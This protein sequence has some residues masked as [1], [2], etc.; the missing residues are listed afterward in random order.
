MRWCVERRLPSATLLSALLAAGVI[1]ESALS[2]TVTSAGTPPTGPA[3]FWAGPFAGAQVLGSLST[4]STTESIAATGALFHHFDAFASGAGGGLNFGYNWLPWG[5]KWL[6]GVVADINFLSDSGGHVFETMDN[7]MA[8]GQMR[9]GYLMAPSLL[10]YGQTGVSLARESLKVDFGGPITEQSR[11]AP[12]YAI[13][14]GAEWA[15]PIV[16]PKPLAAA[17]SLFVEYQH[18]WWSRGTLEMPAA[19]PSLN[20]NWQ[21]E[22]NTI[23]AGLRF[24]F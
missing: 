22:S 1:P 8:S 19:V 20:F 14:A 4:V 21:R 5:N 24:H 3:I 18:I 7:L 12:G 15:L 13:G 10:C 11:V 6:A 16:P 2:Q 23:K 17:P 9:V